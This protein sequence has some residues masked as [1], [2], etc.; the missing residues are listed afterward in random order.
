MIVK[1]M[2]SMLL[3]L[4]LILSLGACSKSSDGGSQGE[5]KDKGVLQETPDNRE[6]TGADQR[7]QEVMERLTSD[8][9]HR[10]YF[11]VGSSPEEADYTYYE[12]NEDGFFHSFTYEP[13]TLDGV[14]YVH[15]REGTYE[16]TDDKIVYTYEFTSQSG[17]ET[18]EDSFDYTYEEGAFVLSVPNGNLHKS[19]WEELTEKMRTDSFFVIDDFVLGE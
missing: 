8:G 9:G 10:G 16:I 4:S 18:K 14:E 13:S 7:K 5:S 1:R 11:Y 12:F 2:V 19:N 17:M 6:D 15:G 3:A